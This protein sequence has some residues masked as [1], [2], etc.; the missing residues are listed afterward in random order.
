MNLMQTA[1]TLFRR[2]IAGVMLASCL[3]PCLL[4]ADM[5]AFPFGFSNGSGMKL[6]VRRS[7]DGSNLRSLGGAMLAADNYHP[8][9]LSSANPADIHAL[10]ALLARSGLNDPK[11][12]VSR[13]DDVF[14]LPSE[15]PAAILDPTPAAD[16]IRPVNPKFASLPLAFAVALFPPGT[17]LRKLPATT[18]LAWTRGLQPD[19]TWS[20]EHA[21]Y[22][23]WGGY[24]VF[25]GG[26]MEKYAAKIG[27]RLVKFG[28]T[29][30][31]SDIREALPPS[32]RIS[33]YHPPSGIWPARY[34]HRCEA[35]LSS[36]GS[37][38]GEAAV[39]VLLPTLLLGWAVWNQRRG[40]GNFADKLVIAVC[41]LWLLIILPQ[42]FGV[43]I[44]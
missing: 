7:V 34:D 32:T 28:T 42:F 8:G 22:G 41:A 29:Q 23:D 30:P 38:L 26:N 20:K 1:P 31:T 37:A 18:P 5:T 14:P 35:R 13:V 17:E 10:A 27:G 39:I 40:R 44:G 33:E 36:I 6:S 15:F 21:T 3:M 43:L 12:W 19:G 25:A 11:L 16:G 9:A 2:L 4:R 24:M